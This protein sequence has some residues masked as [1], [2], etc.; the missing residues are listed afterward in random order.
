LET[1]FTTGR[2]GEGTNDEKKFGGRGAVDLQALNFEITW[3]LSPTYEILYFSR[4]EPVVKVS[5]SRIKAGKG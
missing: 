3:I 2:G 4:G 1:T 5:L